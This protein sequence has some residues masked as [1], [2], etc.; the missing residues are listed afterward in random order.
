MADSDVASDPENYLDGG[1]GNDMDMCIKIMCLRGFS[2]FF[3]RMLVVCLL[4]ILCFRILL[5]SLLVV[6]M[7]FFIFR[8][9]N[10]H[11]W[12]C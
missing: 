9:L 11:T 1:H 2:S 4:L 10:P 12:R 8:F 3:F 7:F 5:S 6:L